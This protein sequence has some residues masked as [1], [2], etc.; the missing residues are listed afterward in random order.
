MLR[1]TPTHKGD[2]RCRLLADRH[3]SRQRPGHP[4]WTRPGYNYVLYLEHEGKGAV[5]CW[6][7]PKWEAGVGRFDGLQALECTIFRNETSHRSSELVCEA[8]SALYLPEAE[9]ALSIKEPSQLLL[10]TGVSS[11]KTAKG[12]SRNSLPG[13]CFRHAG[14]APFEHKKGKADVWLAFSHLNPAKLWWDKPA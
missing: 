13:A 1:W 11:P 7:R 5:W 12:R 2:V 9:Q 8:V 3:Y 6:W 14:W 4:M 10:I